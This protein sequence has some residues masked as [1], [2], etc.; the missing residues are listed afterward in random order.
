MLANGWMTRFIKYDFD[1]GVDTYG[2]FYLVI[3]IIHMIMG[4]YSVI[5]NDE[6]HKFH[7]Y[8][9]ILGVFLIIVNL[10]E[11]GLFIW[12]YNKTKE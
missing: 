10:G 3:T 11:L 9:G 5:D 6:S 12:F 8:S 2:W 1:D 4:G 7:N